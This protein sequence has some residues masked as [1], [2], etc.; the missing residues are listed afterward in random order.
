M[1]IS[2]R[3]NAVI[4]HPFTQH[5]TM[6]L[7]GTIE[8]GEG[9][10]L[11]EQNGKRLLDLI[12]SWWVNLH[13]HA[14]P[15]I[16]KAIYEQAM[17]LEH[18]IFASFTHEPAVTLAEQLLTIL[19]N[20]FSKI[21]YSDN[22]STSVE[23]ALKMAYQFWRNI[24]EKRRHRFIAFENGYHGDTFG[25]MSVG[26]KSGFFA[27]FEDLFFQVDFMPYP[28]T[29]KDDPN[30]KAKE[31][32]ALEKM[33]AHLKKYGA[34]T[35]ALII[36]PLVQGSSGMQM[37]SPEFLQQLE[38]LVRSYGI[39]IIYD[40]VMTG[41]GRTGDYFACLKA[42]TTPDIICISKGL[43]GGFLPIAVTACSE[44]IY[45]AFL[46][47][48]FSSALVHGHTFT[49]NP[50][51]CA[52]AVASLTILKR[53]ETQ[54]QINMIQAVHQAALTNLAREE[55]VEKPR[56]CGTI[57]AFNLKISAAY[58][59]STS[60][61]L[62]EQFRQRGLL[63]RPIGN[64]IYIM[65]PYCISETELKRSYEIVIEEIQGVIA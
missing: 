9:V 6:P 43:T 47:D 42:N 5:K 24:G 48:D 44:Q 59:A 31:Q 41:L 13:G 64:A 58:G 32:E 54:Q 3:D 22:G 63:I 34:E 25:A 60:V 27:Q 65:P 52:A 26:R 56:S 20:T 14:N 55:L 17:K 51:A 7:P 35:A 30:I 38:T 37:C 10:Y 29:W 40:E 8:R 45:Q 4:W 21:F 18:V 23:I 2:E 11:I 15:E 39:L 1:T 49:A 62:R 19:P 57:A 50:I 28:A 12:S 53:E 61:K 16:A 33:D 46:G 36:E